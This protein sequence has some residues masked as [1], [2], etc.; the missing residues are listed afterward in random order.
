M[1]A[2]VITMNVTLQIILSSTWFVGVLLTWVILGLSN[3]RQSGRGMPMLDEPLVL[4]IP[5]FAWPLTWLTY[6]VMRLAKSSYKPCD[7]I[8]PVLIELVF[9][10]S[11]G[12]VLWIFLLGR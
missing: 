11:L 9:V 6:L 5:S 2:T 4:G 7:A 3:E 12:S 1:K 10:V 8:S